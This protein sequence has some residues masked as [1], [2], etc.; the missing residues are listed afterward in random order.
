M[1][2][3]RDGEVNRNIDIKN[4]NALQLQEH[5]EHVAQPTIKY[6]HMMR[7]KK[8]KGFVSHPLILVCDYFMIAMFGWCFIVNYN[9]M[10]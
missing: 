6:N 9:M 7:S 3:C 1:R 2:F 8:I 5:K 4:K 10:Y